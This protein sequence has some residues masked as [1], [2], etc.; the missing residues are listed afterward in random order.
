MTG[1]VAEGVSFRRGSRSVLEAVSVIVKPGELVAL[2]GPNGAGKSTLLRTMAGEYR[3]HAGY[4]RL[5]ELEIDHHPNSELARRRA[6]LPQTIN[7]DFPLRVSEVIAL[8]RAPWYRHADP[9]RNQNAIL[10]AAKAVG[11]DALMHRR[12]NDLSGGERQRVQLA[13]VL[14]QIWDT[15][16]DDIPR[17]LLLDE[18]TASLD[19]GHQ[20]RLLGVARTVLAQGIGVLAVLHDLNLAAAYADR[21]Y[22]MHKGR[23]V[24]EGAP[25]A[26]LC[27]N[28]LQSI[29]DA[30]LDVRLDQT[31]GRLMVLP[32]AP[33]LKNGVK[34]PEI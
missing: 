14:A 29:Y 10:E 17:Y 1:L 19:V 31:T 7:V 34:P 32:C 27:A 5:D 6:V 13:R 11:A 24:A 16:W 18:P 8:G 28:R 3:P 2:I 23:I 25:A 26:V 20:L 22:L 30:A 12:Y 21:L 4:C 9:A 33:V 15:H